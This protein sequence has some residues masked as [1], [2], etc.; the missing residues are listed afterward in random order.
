MASGASPRGCGWMLVSATASSAPP[1]FL[2]T[3]S[4]GRAAA[5]RFSSAA[6][7]SNIDLTIRYAGPSPRHLQRRQA[8]VGRSRIGSDGGHRLERKVEK[9]A[10]INKP[11]QRVANLSAAVAGVRTIRIHETREKAVGPV[12]VD[13]GR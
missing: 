10:R 4:E 13:S 8:Y 5:L 9:T 7:D 3:S 1:I 2:A 12:R 11:T 6:S